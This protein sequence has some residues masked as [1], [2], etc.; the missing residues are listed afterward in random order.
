MVKTFIY[1]TMFIRKPKWN[2]LLLPVEDQKLVYFMI[3]LI[4]YWNLFCWALEYC[5]SERIY[6]GRIIHLWDSYFIII[7]LK[8]CNL[9]ELPTCLYI[10]MCRYFPTTQPCHNCRDSAATWERLSKTWKTY[11]LSSQ[12]TYLLKFV[13]WLLFSK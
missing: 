7:S 13:M 2:S 10:Y 5:F 1:A 4:L 9:S 6:E 12:F 3:L 8:S 11:Y